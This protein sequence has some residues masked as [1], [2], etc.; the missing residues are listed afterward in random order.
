VEKSIGV[1]KKKV[2]GEIRVKHNIRER[3][4]LKDG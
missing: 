4:E 1:R 3:S 2:Y